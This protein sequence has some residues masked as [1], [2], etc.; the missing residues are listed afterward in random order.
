[1]KKN[2]LVVIAGMNNDY[3]VCLEL[4]SQCL[5]E[6]GCSYFGLCFK[7]PQLTAEF[8]TMKNVP[9]ASALTLMLLSR[10]SSRRLPYS[11]GQKGAV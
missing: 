1:M 8:P 5:S 4:N 11:E 9:S 7:V 10:W 6:S 3:Y 2:I